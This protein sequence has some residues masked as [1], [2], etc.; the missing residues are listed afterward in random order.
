MYKIRELN[1]YV[2]IDTIKES[3]LSAETVKKYHVVVTTELPIPRQLDINQWC[4][5]GGVKFVSA[6]CR[7]AFCRVLNDFGDSFEVL[8]KNGE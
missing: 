7:G 3:E 2:K 4:R 8:D 1:I 5:A 6:E